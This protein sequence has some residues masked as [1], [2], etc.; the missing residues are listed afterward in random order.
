MT[1]MRRWGQISEQKSDDWYKDMAKKV[2]RPDIYK[3][4][5]EE[6]IADGTFKKSD[7]SDVY[8]TDGFRGVQDDFMDGIPYDGSKPNEY[9]DSM[10]IGLK[11]DKTL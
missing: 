11:G 6:L 10:K 2:Y 4:A 3:Q 8:A 5:V 7:F 1:Q 9:I